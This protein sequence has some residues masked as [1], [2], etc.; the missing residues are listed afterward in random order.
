MVNLSCIQVEVEQELYLRD[1]NRTVT[2]KR[3]GSA[4]VNVG[5]SV[6]ADVSVTDCKNSVTQADL[7]EIWAA[8]V[9]ERSILDVM[10][11]KG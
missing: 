1:I 6:K 4:K 9:Q 3:E 5:A 11:P 2:A 10:K 8:R 7:G